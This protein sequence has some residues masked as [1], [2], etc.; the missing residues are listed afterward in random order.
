MEPKLDI[1]HK[2]I[3]NE[4]KSVSD[5]KEVLVVGAGD[6]KKDYHLIKDGYNVYSTDYQRAPW[7]DKNMET[8]FN[9]LNYNISNIFDL[10]SFPVKTCEIVMCCEVLEHLPEYKKAVTNLL[11]LTE[12]RLIITVPW[13]HS[14]NDPRP[15]PEGHC[16]YWD[17]DGSGNYKNIHE[18]ESMVTP[19]KIIF[20]K[21]RTKPEDVQRG[22][23]SYLIIIDK[24]S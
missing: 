4:V 21:I 2:R 24:I 1:R 18:F 17:D 9:E 11:E 6:C 20:E 15:S 23:Y 5:K 13:R 8:Y 10:E 22:Q 7:F 19:H 3:I 12:K 14:F 16:N